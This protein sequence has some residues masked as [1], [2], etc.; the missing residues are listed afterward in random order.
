MAK[1]E[2][3]KI[4][5]EE[6]FEALSGGRI[7]DV[8]PEKRKEIYRHLREC[9]ECAPDGLLLVANGSRETVAE[10]LE[11]ISRNSGARRHDGWLWNLCGVFAAPIP[12]YLMVAACIS[13]AVILWFGRDRGSSYSQDT[14]QAL[15]GIRH[16]AV[17]S[18][19]R[20]NGVAFSFTKCLHIYETDPSIPIIGDRPKVVHTGLAAEYRML[21]NPACLVEKV[22]S[23]PNNLRGDFP[24]TLDLLVNLGKEY[25]EQRAVVRF[26]PSRRRG[27]VHYSIIRTGRNLTDLP[28][29]SV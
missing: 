23:L 7:A 1:Q 19:P 8:S 26:S 24:Q 17:W 27:E 22:A 15:Y 3:R 9:P 14:F 18:T 13:I 2:P 25:K 20:R 6:Y 4:T 12:R 16:A 5:C 21:F 11:F 29:D 10:Y 28:S